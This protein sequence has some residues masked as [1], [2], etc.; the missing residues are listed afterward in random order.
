[1]E[2]RRWQFAERFGWTLDY[3]DTLTLA[4]FDDFD[5]YLQV[6]DGMNKGQAFLRAKK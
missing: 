5:Q 1:M 2:F 4:D 6:L 3:I